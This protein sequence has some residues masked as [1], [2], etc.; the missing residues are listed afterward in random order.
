M[1]NFDIENNYQGKIIAGIDE[2]GRGSIAGPVVCACVILNR[3]LLIDGICDSKKLSKTKLDY[4]YDHIT[5]NH[6]YSLGII[7]NTEIDEINIL[8]ATKKACISASESLKPQ[9]DIILVD[10]NMKFD[11]QRYISIIKGDDKSLSIA[12]ASIVAKVTRDRIMQE[13]AKEFNYYHWEKN[14]G[15]GT[16]NH[17]NAIT[18]YGISKYHR[19]TFSIKG[20][21]LLNYA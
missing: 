10:G 21:K 5:K 16:K 11:D 7:S 17:I 9:A 18:K 4:F 3:D 15:Y 1:P 2:V 14:V 6:E 20:K 12:A 8:E 19:K 13:I